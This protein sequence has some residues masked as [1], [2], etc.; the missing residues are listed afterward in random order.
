MAQRPPAVTATDQPGVVDVGRLAR[1]G[2]INLVGAVA[3]AGTNL[4]ITVAV[5]RTMSIAQA[6]AFFTV[7]SIFLILVACARLG[8]GSALTYF[9][10]RL[11]ATGHP[12]LVRPCL[13]IALAP[14]VGVSLLM[15]VVLLVVAEP[16][17]GL[18]D[19]QH[20]GTIA[21]YLRVLAF[22]LPFAATSEGVLGATRGF[23][24]M[25]PTVVV[26]KVARP[27][28]Q[29]LGILVLAAVGGAAIVVA[30]SFPYVPAVLAGSAWLSHLRRRDHRAS[31][32]QRREP[33]AG[34][35]REYW[36]FAAPRAIA[37]LLQVAL[38][39][40]D[41]VLVAVMLGGPASAIYVV[42]TRLLVL[43]A[44]GIQA[45]SMAVQPQVAAHHARGE[46]AAVN[47]L[48]RT[49]TTWLILATW[50]LY[51]VGALF[52]PTVLRLFGPEYAAG[53]SVLVI[54]AFATMLSTACGVVDAMLTMAGRPSW[55]LGNVTL[56]LVVNVS[57]NLVLIPRWGIEGAA[58]AWSASILV[59]NLRPLLQL[60]RGLGMHPFGRSLALAMVAVLAAYV[61]V[62]LCC[63]LTIG[64]DLAALLTTVLVG[65]G[66]LAVTGWHFRD[67]LALRELAGALRRRRAQ[68]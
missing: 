31:R 56:A 10:A 66:I 3:S 55:I 40:L 43:G 53:A 57:L 63:R 60:Y 1:G 22:A 23:G 24:A 62:G 37:A 25:R 47:L 50:P 15:G 44:L 16:V 33:T 7:T 68:A 39:R 52:A 65:T 8:S 27:I 42:S 13:R 36:R 64:Q 14:V 30:W 21:T 26:E 11:R 38:Q 28:V 45:I 5:T 41:V 34:L 51:V 54:L 32:E 59:N 67:L 61:P 9:V 19:E 18:L 58:V 4:L 46:V 17:A 48:Y 2:S 20:A 6:G 12:G 29:L 49:S 35:A